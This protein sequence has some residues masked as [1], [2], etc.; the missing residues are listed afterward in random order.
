MEVMEVME[1]AEEDAGNI[2]IVHNLQSMKKI[3]FIIFMVS[4]ILN[5]YLLS[6]YFHS[7]T[8]DS[9]SQNEQNTV[10]LPTPKEEPSE[11]EEFNETEEFNEFDFQ[12]TSLELSLSQSP[13]AMVFQNISSA[14]GKS[15]E[16]DFYPIEIPQK[17][18][19]DLF[20]Q[21]ADS[22]DVCE[23]I[24]V[25]LAQDEVQLECQYEYYLR[26]ALE[27][28]TTDNIPV[29]I[30]ESHNL[31]K[32]IKEK[33]CDIHQNYACMLLFDDENIQRKD[34]LQLSKKNNIR[35]DQIPFY[36]YGYYVFQND[37]NDIKTVE[38]AIDILYDKALIY[39]AVYKNDKE[40][41]SEISTVSLSEY[42]E[43][44]FD[45]SIKTKYKD[46]FDD[47]YA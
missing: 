19:T 37:I 34:L 33:K 1:A 20:F 22:L 11:K 18:T 46:I 12:K 25:S 2:R 42:C 39:R 28:K 15:G 14:L 6:L 16:G 40:I 10:S 7:D 44:S 45:S 3:I 47:F 8:E 31:L 23:T 36:S 21:F 13:N 41:C 43:D 32:N 27:E 30:I 9:L 29:T 26:K 4:I 38:D 5:G 35:L 17:L 24:E